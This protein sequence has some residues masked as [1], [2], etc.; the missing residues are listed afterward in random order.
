MV[1]INRRRKLQHMRVLT[2]RMCGMTRAEIASSLGLCKERIR[3]ILRGAA[4]RGVF[5]MRI[6][7]KIEHGDI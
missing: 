2:M 1:C 5:T 6:Y 3:A 7:G 4:Y